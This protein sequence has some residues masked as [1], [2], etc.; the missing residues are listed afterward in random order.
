MDKNPGLTFPLFPA[1]TSTLQNLLTE[2]FCHGGLNLETLFG[3]QT[4]YK[5]HI[6]TGWLK[7]EGASG[8]HLV[9]PLLQQGHP[10][11]GAQDHIQTNGLWEMSKDKTPQL[12]RAT[13]LL[14]GF[15]EFPRNEQ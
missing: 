9:H 3:Q 4:S 11:W 12:L 6:I 1:V 10:K 13:T 15:V 5:F 2:Q 7:W 8:G 14:L